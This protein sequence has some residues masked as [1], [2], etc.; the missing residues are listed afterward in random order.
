[1]EK[2]KISPVVTV[3]V[4]RNEVFF[5]PGVV[6][7][8]DALKETGSMKRACQVSGISY[9]KAWGILR[10]AEEQLGCPV[11]IR[12]HGGAD[13][14]GC[15]VTEM[16]EDLMRK[17][18]LATKEINHFSNEVFSRIFNEPQSLSETLKIQK[19]EQIA[20]TG[21]GGKT[22]VLNLLGEEL[23]SSKVLL[24]T[25]TKMQYP[26]CEEAEKICPQE[27]VGETIEGRTFVYGNLTNQG[28]CTAVSLEKLREMRS[29]YDYVIVEADGSKGLPLKGYF[30]DEPCVP[31]NTDCVIGIATTNGLGRILDERVALRVEKFGEMTN[32]SPGEIIRENHIARWI[33]HSTGMFKNNSK[34]NI[35][36]FNQVESKQQREEALA[37]VGCFQE[38]FKNRLERVVIG[39]TKWK[40]YETIWKNEDT[41]NED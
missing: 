33:E 14:G 5:G 15:E 9:S 36:F 40:N 22:T 38:K 28:K 7:I 3:R 41:R 39:S 16:G 17:Y 10:K 37:I 2:K 30:E 24:T 29:E 13:G 27:A 18:R 8:L 6:L 31:L 1:M 32:M 19:G 25:T 35:L 21:A 23:K 34:R 26:R 20:L 12:K 11:V 4:A